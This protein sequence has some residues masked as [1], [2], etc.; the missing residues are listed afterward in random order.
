MLTLSSLRSVLTSALFS[1]KS[2]VGKKKQELAG[3][4]LK[5]KRET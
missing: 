2:L 4:K 1:L 3:L 5:I